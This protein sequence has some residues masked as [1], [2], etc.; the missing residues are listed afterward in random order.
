MSLFKVWKFQTLLSPIW[1]AFAAICLAQN[2]KQPNSTS[3]NTIVTTISKN[4]NNITTVDTSESDA[5]TNTTTK[6]TEDED[7][8]KTVA[9]SVSSSPGG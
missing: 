8:N 7:A 6:G 9:P 5:L 4:T 2:E 3:I 1:F